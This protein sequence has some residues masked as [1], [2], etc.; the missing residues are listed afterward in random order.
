MGFDFDTEG[1]CF[2]APNAF[3]I[4]LSSDVYDEE[5]RP[6]VEGWYKLM[7]EYAH[8]IQDRTTLFG[9]ID[10]LLFYDWIRAAAEALQAG[11][12]Q[13]HLPLNQAETTQRKVHEI[14]GLKKAVQ[15][16][17]DWMNGKWWAFESFEY[18]DQA[19]SYDGEAQTFKVAMAHFVDN[20]DNVEYSHPIGPRE[21]KEAYSMAV[22]TFFGGPH[23]VTAEQFEYLAV[24]RILSQFGVVDPRQTV[25]ICHWALQD[26]S[27]GVRFFEICELMKTLGHST[28]PSAESLYD[29]LRQDAI[30]RGFL[31]KVAT[32][33]RQLSE[34][35]RIQ[36]EAGE[37]DFLSGV[38]A[39]YK[40]HVFT[41]LRRSVDP[42]RRFPLDTCLCMPF[43]VGFSSTFEVITAE[44]P[45][46]LVALAS[47]RV[48]GYGDGAHDDLD[49]R[50]GFFFRAMGDLL[51]RLWCS[52]HARGK[53]PLYSLC[54]LVFKDHECMERPW[55][56]GD[57]ESP[58]SYG[59]AAR[60]L[61]IP[62]QRI[63]I[64]RLRSQ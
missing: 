8:L 42:T 49:S 32:L 2:Y 50:A 23:V 1:R 34:V 26:P 53:C 38:L 16:R 33:E 60:Y 59:L 10:F 4:N 18:V 22:Q 11:G 55:M 27:P 48:I 64:E 31:D 6:T 30:N 52:D 3:Y 41:A 57:L 12:G 61:G 62:A 46:P 5:D 9:A 17:L 40:D 14:Y 37:D 56:K 25:S 35:Q 45:I 36:S 47:G 24:E 13:I 19:I 29:T 51:D 63:P 58:C 39:W 21:I 15:V 43:S 20:V 54:D 44:E 28:L 7:H